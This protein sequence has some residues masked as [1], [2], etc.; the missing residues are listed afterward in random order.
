MQSGRTKLECDIYSES[1]GHFPPFLPMLSI[2]LSKLFSGY[3]LEQHKF[4]LFVCMIVNS[5]FT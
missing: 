1:R 5:W 4:L 2:E 3:N